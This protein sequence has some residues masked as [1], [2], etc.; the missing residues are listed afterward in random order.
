MQARPVECAVHGTCATAGWRL[1]R[2]EQRDQE[3]AAA[4]LLVCLRRVARCTSS[5][6]TPTATTQRCARGATFVAC[7]SWAHATGWTLRSWSALTGTQA[8]AAVC[9]AAAVSGA[10]SAAAGPWAGFLHM[11]LSVLCMHASSAGFLRMPHALAGLPAQAASAGAFLHMHAAAPRR[12]ARVS[13][14]RRGSCA[15]MVL[16]GSSCAG[17]LVHPCLQCM[18]AL[19]LTLQR[20][21]HNVCC[22]AKI[23][24]LPLHAIMFPRL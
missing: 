10:R 12:P 3:H 5:S 18:H 4:V 16:V 15:G 14:F 2:A 13:G 7:R 24:T 6:C 22:S 17:V 9:W 19:W 1:L 20:A 21:L 8:A 23:H 11:Q